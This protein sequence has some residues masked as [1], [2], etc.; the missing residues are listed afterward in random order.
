[1]FNTN[2]DLRFKTLPKTNLSI[3]VNVVSDS[4]D[5]NHNT[6]DEKWVQKGSHEKSRTHDEFGF[7]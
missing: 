7:S 2:N 3:S 4:S 1:M 5:N 6:A